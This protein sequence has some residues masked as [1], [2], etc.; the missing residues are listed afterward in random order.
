MN[1]LAR[2]RRLIEIAYSYWRKKEKLNYLPIRLW[3]ELSSVCNLRCIMCPQ[4]EPGS[5]EQG[6]MKFELFK[7]IIDEAK[8]FVYDVNLHH[9]GESLLHPELPRMIDYAAKA[10]LYTRLHTNATILDEEK[11]RAILEAELD[12]V[13]FSF[14]G[15]TAEIY[16]KIRRRANFEIT[17]SHISNFLRLKKELRKIKPFTVFETMELDKAKTTDYEKAKRRLREG[18]YA[19]HLNKFVVK[20]PHNWAG[21]YPINSNGAQKNTA[22]SEKFSACTFPWY[23][24]VILWN[25]EI[26]PCPQDF[27]GHLIMGNLENSSIGAIWHNNLYSRLRK[28]MKEREISEFESCR[29]CDML[30]R[31]TFLHIPVPNLKVFFKEIFF[32]HR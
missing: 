3:V 15:F 7:K 24:M 26:A 9:R 12:F 28:N 10:G 21:S 5:I 20:S 32:G 17:I 29:E 25:G 22:K 8:T 27:F 31:R 30:R 14:D 2:S 1:K 19:L 6:F 11:A 4:S 13:S 18:L 23:A 16:E